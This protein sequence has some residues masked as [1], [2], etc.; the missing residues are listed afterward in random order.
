LSRVST[1][2]IHS[3]AIVSESAVLGDGVEI[4]P[5]TVIGDDVRIGDRSRVMAHTVIEGPTTIGVDNVIYPFVSLGQG[6]QDLKYAGESTQLVVGDRNSIREYSNFH[7][8][9]VGGGGVT[10]VG[11]DNLFMVATHIAHDCSVGN[12]IIMANQ[13]TLAGHVTVEDFTTVGA[14][15]SV[16]QFTRVGKHA[17]VGGHSVIVKDP[18]PFSRCQGNHAKCYGENAIGL[19]RKGFG[20]DT[21]RNLHRAFR[22]LLSSGLNT[23]QAVDAIQA[24]AALLADENVAYIV[25]F[26]E[27]SE[28][29]VIKK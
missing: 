10:R 4:G 12:H 29:G 13:A 7:R 21:I 5:Y 22:L 11:N 25:E 1:R 19:R 14:A 9:T 16:H 6:P 15:S 20:D 27:T 3:T 18:L 26:I 28:R 2:K 23:A 17:F 8:G 24:D